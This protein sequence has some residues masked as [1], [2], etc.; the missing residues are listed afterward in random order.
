MKYRRYRFSKYDPLLRDGNGCY[1][2]TD[3]TSVDDIGKIFG[4]KVLT[5]E[6]YEAV[7]GNYLDVV[8]YLMKRCGVGNMV[9]SMAEKH[10]DEPE[11]SRNEGDVVDADE[12]RAI[13]RSML[14]ERYWCVL[15]S[16][17]THFML[18][19]GCDFYLHVICRELTRE[20]ICYAERLGLFADRLPQ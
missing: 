17:D 2:G 3:W 1:T 15:Y 5:Q 9:V 18:D 7:V 13:C 16:R 11:C 10:C 19:C 6:D 14:E 20:E 12:V 8:S 4:G